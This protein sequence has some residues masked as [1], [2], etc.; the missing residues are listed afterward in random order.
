MLAWLSLPPLL[1]RSA[2]VVP[3]A[4]VEA[5]HFTETCRKPNLNVCCLAHQ[6]YLLL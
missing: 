5:R 4:A 3:I 6:K 1:I 2:D